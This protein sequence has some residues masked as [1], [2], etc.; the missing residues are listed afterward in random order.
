MAKLNSNKSV[1]SAV[2]QSDP[3][4][5]PDYAKQYAGQVIHYVGVHANGSGGWHA[6]FFTTPTFKFD[7]GS[8]MIFREAHIAQFVYES[9]VVLDIDID[10]DCEADSWSPGRHHLDGCPLKETACS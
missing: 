6:P 2:L 9:D 10:C 5:L 7:D 3:R 8:Y 1:H 4:H